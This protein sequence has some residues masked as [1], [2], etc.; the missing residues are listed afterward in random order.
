MAQNA[1]PLMNFT[2]QV[3]LYGA[4]AKHIMMLIGGD[5]KKSTLMCGVGSQSVWEWVIMDV[6][7]AGFGVGTEGPFQC[8]LICD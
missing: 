5:I 7:G 1:L 6:D 4:V 8:T 3:L 2:C